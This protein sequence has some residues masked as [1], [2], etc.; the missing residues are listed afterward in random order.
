MEAIYKLPSHLCLAILSILIVSSSYGQALTVTGELKKWHPVTITLDGPQ[1]SEDGSPNP[2]LDYRFEVSFSLGQETITVPGYFAADGNAA[3]TGATSGNKWRA[4]FVPPETGTWTFRTSFRQGTDVAL[5]TESTAGSS[6]AP[7]DNVFSTVT[8]DDTDKG[9]DDFRGKGVLRYTGASYMQFDN[10]EYYIKGG[11]DSP[12]NFLAYQDFD[13]TYSTGSENFVKSYTAHVS[14]WQEGDPTWQNGKGKGIIGG[15]NYLASEGVNSIYFITM[16]IEG[17][18]KDVW[19]YTSHTERLR[20]DVSKLAQ[21]DIVFKHMTQ[22]G[23]KLHVVTQETE[24]ELLLDGGTLGRER[25]AYFKEL[26]A[27]FG[28]HN[29]VIWNLGEENNQTAHDQR[30][31]YADY[32]RAFDAYDHPIVIHT[33]PGQWDLVYGP[34]LGNQNFEGPSIQIGTPEDAHWITL[35]WINKSANAGRKWI[36]TIDESGPWQDGATPDGPDNNHWLI[37]REILWGNLM[38]GGAGVE[39]YFGYE[40]PNNDFNAEDFRSRDLFWDYTRHALTFF[41]TY[42][43]FYEMTS[44]DGLSSDQ[45]SYVFGKEDEIYAVYLKWGGT[46]NLNLN[47]SSKTYTIEWFNPRTGGS[48]VNG[49]I[50]EITGP[51][52]VSIGQP[53]SEQS[54]DWVA[55]IKEKVDNLYGDVSGDGQVSAFDASLVLQHSIGLIILPENLLPI[56]DVSGNGNISAFDG[57][58][59]LQHVINLISCF[60]ADGN[61]AGKQSSTASSTPEISWHLRQT[62]GTPQDIVLK[63]EP[64]STPS[65]SIDLTINVAKSAYDSYEY[66]LPSDWQVFV[67]EDADQLRI[68]GA[69]IATQ[70]PE[71]LITLRLSNDNKASTANVIQANLSLNES[72]LGIAVQTLNETPNTFSLENNYPNPFN[73]QT[74]IRYSLPEAAHVKLQVFDLTG[75]NVASLVN[76]V[77]TEG[78]YAIDFDASNLPSGVYVYRLEANDFQQTKKMTLLK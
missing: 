10:G 18:T 59:I 33:L 51:G 8:I 35:D 29:A 75:R 4:H 12:E 48:L 25:K 52:S 56:A 11:T 57:S 24:N 58:M 16:N 62:P 34:F 37:R 3:E 45:N 15:V 64:S 43:P 63:H 23:I 6:F 17:D 71:D 47:G 78:E 44:L 77:Q 32:I 27:R 74:T 26:V 30:Q 13:A 70:L 60:P 49:T 72:P 31:A 65:Q 42:L 61:C 14:D 55:L 41:N 68:A 2:F 40:H 21:W 9:G 20:F 28:Y 7:Y 39:W 76:E 73:P 69:G 50:A 36:V 38:A 5:S 67:H 1:A 54:E 22:K 46:A 66:H 53:P 19:M